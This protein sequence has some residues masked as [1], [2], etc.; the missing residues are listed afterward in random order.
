MVDKGTLEGEFYGAVEYVPSEHEGVNHLPHAH[1][2]WHLQLL[3]ATQI[4]GNRDVSL[5][6][7]TEDPWILD[8][9]LDQQLSVSAQITKE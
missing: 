6:K 3:P 1:L 8:P 2:S 5:G 7:K 9:G 4:H